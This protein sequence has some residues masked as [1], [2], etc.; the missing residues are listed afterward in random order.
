MFS[1]ETAE[2]VAAALEL[3]DWVLEKSAAWTYACFGFFGDSFED[4]VKTRFPEPYAAAQQWVHVNQHPFAKRL[5]YLNPWHCIASILGYFAVIVT[6]R[7]FG[8]FLGKCTCRNLGLFHNLGLHLLSLYMSVGLMVSARAAGYTVW[9]NAAGTSRAEWRIA[10]LI[11]LFYVSKV[12][13]W[14]DTLIMLLKQNYHQVSFLHIYHH[15]TIF[16]MWWL[17]SMKAP[18]GEAYYS[19]MVNS[20]IHVVMYGYYFLTL[21]F[22]SGAVRSVLNRFK[23]VITKGQMTQFA[24]NCMQSAYD[25]VLVPRAQLKYSAP[26][27]QALF[28]YMISLLALFGN[29]LMKGSKRAHHHTH[30]AAAA[31]HSSVA[32]K[33]ASLKKTGE[34]DAVKVGMTKVQVREQQKLSKHKNGTNGTSASQKTA[35]HPNAATQAN[36]EPVFRH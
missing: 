14:V 24:F 31:E 34:G 5:P 33:E 23:F 26:L 2:Q 10:K 25:L 28:W 7:L 32:A 22:P 1:I 16:A 27:L 36:A 29:F 11:W 4:I 19:A 35:I 21:L 17:A 13:E 9:N 30:R 8:R 15:A 18:G 3:P 20:A 12:V 6:F